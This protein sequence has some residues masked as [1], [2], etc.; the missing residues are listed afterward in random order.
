MINIV[1]G[2]VSSVILRPSAVADAYL[3]ELQSVQSKEV[4]QMWPMNFSPSARF[5]EAKI[6]EISGTPQTPVPTDPIPKIQLEY[7]GS[8]LYTLYGVTASGVTQSNTI[9]DSGKALFKNNEWENYF[10]EENI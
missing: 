4:F 7:S 1:A 3:L 5:F 8:Y 2:T 6:Y 10:G 9:L